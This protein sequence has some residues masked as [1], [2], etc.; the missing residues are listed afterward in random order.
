MPELT[1]WYMYLQIGFYT[2]WRNKSLIILRNWNG[3]K[4]CKKGEK[5]PLL[6]IMLLLK[7]CAD[8]PLLVSAKCLL[9][10]HTNGNYHLAV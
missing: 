5:S 6:H 4:E 10:Y 1:L 3:E 8:P 9:K 7:S 2:C